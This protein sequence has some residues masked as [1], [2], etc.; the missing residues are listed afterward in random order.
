MKYPTSFRLSIHA[1]ALLERMA[2]DLSISQMAMLEI[3]IR[4][5]AKK[6]GIRADSGVQGQ[7]TQGPARRD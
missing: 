3:L 4:E 1:R 6:R 7:A 2:Q 5:G